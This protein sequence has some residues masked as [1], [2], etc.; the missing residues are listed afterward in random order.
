MRTVALGVSFSVCNRSKIL[1]ALFGNG[2]QRWH[3]TAVMMRVTPREYVTI[4][5]ILRTQHTHS[6]CYNFFTRSVHVLVR[7][8]T[9][10]TLKM[11]IVMLFRVRLNETTHS[12]FQLEP[13]AFFDCSQPLIVT[14]N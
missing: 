12:T 8:I 2:W 7:E 14:E 4:P 11:S 6:C 10:C 9:M 5:E 3:V 13:N 1:D